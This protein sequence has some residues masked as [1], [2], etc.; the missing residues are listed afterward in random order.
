MSHIRRNADSNCAYRIISEPTNMYSGRICCTVRIIFT[1][2]NRT[3]RAIIFRDF[4]CVLKNDLN[5]N[6]RNIIEYFMLIGP[7]TVWKELCIGNIVYITVCTWVRAV[8]LAS[9]TDALC[10]NEQNYLLLLYL[11]KISTLCHITILKTD[12]HSA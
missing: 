4:T 10:V 6:S 9:V 3:V 5:V 7:P 8:L 1:F 2:R 12:L 11:L